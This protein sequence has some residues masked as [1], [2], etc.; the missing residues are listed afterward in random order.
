MNAAGF[1]RGICEKCILNA[2]GLNQVLLCVS[3]WKRAYLDQCAIFLIKRVYLVLLDE[4]Q[5]VLMIERFPLYSR[6]D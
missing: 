4:K 3:I 2:A 5:K 6:P 1:H